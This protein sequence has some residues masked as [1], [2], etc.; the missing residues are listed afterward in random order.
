MIEWSSRK[1]SVDSKPVEVETDEGYSF[2]NSIKQ[3]VEDLKTVTDLDTKAGVK[4]LYLV[5]SENVLFLEGH[6]DIS[7]MSFSADTSL[8]AYMTE[9]EK[10]VNKNDSN[11]FFSTIVENSLIQIRDAI[12]NVS[13]SI[14]SE[15]VLADYESNLRTGNKNL[16][17]RIV[18]F[19]REI[20][21]KNSK[22]ELIDLVP[23]LYRGEYGGMKFPFDRDVYEKD[24]MDKPQGY[25]FFE[26]SMLNELVEGQRFFYELPVQQMLEKG[27]DLQVQVTDEGRYIFL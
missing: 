24:L 20:K 14:A 11:D 19:M 15:K 12:E 21:N 10:L 2:V 16:D 4:D 23:L 7:K 8:H 22:R 13:L 27:L 17:R 25:K 6:N 26:D 1:L 3:M 9:V 18:S 5:V